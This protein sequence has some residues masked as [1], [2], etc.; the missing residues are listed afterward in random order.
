MANPMARGTGPRCV[1]DAC[2]SS[3]SGKIQSS[4]LL[5]IHLQSY[6]S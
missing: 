4:P 3:R 6:T 5:K 2:Q 1:H